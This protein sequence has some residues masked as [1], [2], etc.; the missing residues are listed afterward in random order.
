MIS[1]DEGKALI[2]NLTKTYPIYSIPSRGYLTV[3]KR[4]GVYVLI[5][6]MNSKVYV[7]RSVDLKHRMKCH[8]GT[9]DTRRT[10]GA[11]LFNAKEKW[12]NDAFDIHIL[13]Y[14]DRDLIA[15]KEHE[16]LGLLNGY[17]N[18]HYNIR[19]VA[20][21]DKGTFSIPQEQ[22][23]M[24]SKS[25]KEYH[26]TTH[27]AFKGKKHSEHSRKLI[28]DNIRNEDGSLKRG[29]YTEEQRLHLSRLCIERNSIKVMRDWID[30]NGHPRNKSVVALYD[31]GSVYMTFPSI[32]DA[33]LHL[34]KPRGTG[35]N[36]CLSGR[37]KRAYGFNWKYIGD[38]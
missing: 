18:G 24:I 28:A 23:D 7:G 14:L 8:F 10:N 30:E 26:K 5:N 36:N 20:D 35:I 13:E 19:L 3:E 29:E 9:K 6:K 25:L 15:K 11:L 21:D 4:S 12:G 31:D 27:N 37:V 16:L 1:I 34:N 38:I 33:A 2:S 22:R 32:K 17:E